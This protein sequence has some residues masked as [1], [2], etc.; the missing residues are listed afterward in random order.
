MRYH[1]GFIYLSWC[2]VPDGSVTQRP[3]CS[4]LT[5]KVRVRVLL[6]SY[7]FSKFLELEFYL[8]RNYERN[9]DLSHFWSKK[10]VLSLVI[11]YALQISFTPS[12]SFIENSGHWTCRHVKIEILWQAYSYSMT[13]IKLDIS[14]W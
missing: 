9:H 3:L 14:V 11:E 7:F 13:D 12:N 10:I 6:E 4:S 8:F 2:A 5:A 1:D